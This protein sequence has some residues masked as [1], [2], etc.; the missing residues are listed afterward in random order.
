MYIK[1]FLQSTTMI[2]EDLFNDLNIKGVARTLAAINCLEAPINRKSNWLID[3]LSYFNDKLKKE[4]DIEKVDQ[5]HKE[6]AKEFLAADFNSEI[7]WIKKHVI[8]KVKSPIVFCNNDV[9]PPNVLIRNEV[10]GKIKRLNQIED[11][12]LIEKLIDQLIVIIDFEFCSYNFR[13]CEIGN[14]FIAHTIE[15]NTPDPPHFLADRNKYPDERHQ[16]LF[17]RE[18]LNKLKQIK[19][20]LDDEVDNEDHIM[21][22]VQ[23]YQMPHILFWTL[24][25]VCYANMSM[26]SDQFTFDF[27]VS[28]FKSIQ[29]FN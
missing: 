14:Y 16:R 4:L 15:Y 29:I 27:W 8:N 11:C 3:K 18:Y 24:L 10:L 12:Q 7:E 2:Q 1:K 22:E 23:A 6:I 19:G 17:I 28:P 9:F 13:G 21:Q 25:N 20:N 5:I 26:I